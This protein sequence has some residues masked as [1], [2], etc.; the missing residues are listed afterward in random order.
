MNEDP[1]GMLIKPLDK[2]ERILGELQFKK[3]NYT[4]G[5]NTLIFNMDKQKVFNQV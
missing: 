5:Q 3:I 2:A 4:H 1:E